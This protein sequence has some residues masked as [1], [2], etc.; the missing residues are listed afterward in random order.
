MLKRLD[1]SSSADVRYYMITD[2]ALSQESGKEVR[3][4]GFSNWKLVPEPLVEG[5]LARDTINFSF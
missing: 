3:F 4:D 5:C 1:I 2:F